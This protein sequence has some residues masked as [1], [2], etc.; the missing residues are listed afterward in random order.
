MPKKGHN[1]DAEEKG[2]LA[3]F[4]KGEFKS[5]KNTK[6]E[7]ELAA[8]ASEHFLKKDARINIRLSSYDLDQ[9]K[10]IAVLEGLP[11]KH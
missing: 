9:L 8:Q 5:I 10:R 11:T 1:L 4:E 6:A 7:K 2:L 3:A